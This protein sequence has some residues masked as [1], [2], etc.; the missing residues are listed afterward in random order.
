MTKK[1]PIRQ[2]MGCNERKPKNELV[3]VVRTPEGKVKVDLTGK[4]SGRGAYICRSEKCLQKAVKSGRIGRV[5][6]VSLTDETLDELKSG[7]ES[8]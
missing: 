6:E 5:L 2:C 8:N 1:T 7:V 4:I 3:R